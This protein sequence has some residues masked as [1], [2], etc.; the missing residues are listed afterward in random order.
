VLLTPRHG[1]I[2]IHRTGGLSMA[3]ASQVPVNT[4]ILKVIHLEK[5]DMA[6]SKHIALAGSV[7][8]Y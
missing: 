2:K 7:L 8:V 3:N 5:A 4:G 6:R 1:N